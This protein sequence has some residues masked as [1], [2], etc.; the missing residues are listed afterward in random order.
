[1][2]RELYT[3]QNKTVKKRI[4]KDSSA[5]TRLILH[6]MVLQKVTYRDIKSMKIEENMANK[7]GRA[8]GNQSRKPAGQPVGAKFSIGVSIF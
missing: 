8:R 2:R 4:A 5:S 1:M 3:F 6:A 7:E